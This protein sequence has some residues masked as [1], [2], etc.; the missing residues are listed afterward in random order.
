MKNTK[1][2]KGL[3]T[4]MKTNRKNTIV[5]LIATVL[6]TSM[7]TACGNVTGTFAERKD[8]SKDIAAMLTLLPQ[9]GT[10]QT[11]A[12]TTE[13]P[14][15]EPEET[16]EP[17]EVMTETSEEIA[18]VAQE[19]AEMIPE[20]TPEPT[21]TPEPVIEATPEPVATP[22]PAF[23]ETTATEEPAVTT[24]TTASAENTSETTNPEWEEFVAKA[25]EIAE[26]PYY[27]VDT[28]SDEML[29]AKLD[30]LKAMYPDWS[31]W[32]WDSYYED[33]IV[34]TLDMVIANNN[35]CA[36]FVKM[37]S[38][39]IF[40]ASAPIVWKDVPITELMPGDILPINDNHLIMITGNMLYI[41][42]SPYSSEDVLVVTCD[43]V[44]GNVI[45]NDD[46]SANTG[47]LRWSDA[48]EFSFGLTKND[49]GEW[50]TSV[51]RRQ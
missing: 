32:G 6:C 20:K 25:Y 24:T 46:A 3:V 41:V 28:M 15:P 21:A 35:A 43:M 14:T 36:G 40:G 47:V 1:I 44:Q 48:G 49:E 16:A 30:E 4:T 17:E 39:Y 7:L 19:I 5:K 10:L 13:E 51:I 38:D 18:E 9:T 23:G 2:K 34:S 31:H 27:T 26:S 22:E 42:D 37:A 8:D 50:T 29:F 11:V 33:H 12:R 45:Y